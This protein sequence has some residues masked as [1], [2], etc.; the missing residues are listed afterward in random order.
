[1]CFGLDGFGPCTPKGGL[2]FRVYCHIGALIIRTG[3]W[4]TLYCNYNPI[5][6]IK[7]PTLEAWGCLRW[8]PGPKLCER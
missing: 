8:D 5:L 1:M 7:A 6:I 2:G 3:I 4:G